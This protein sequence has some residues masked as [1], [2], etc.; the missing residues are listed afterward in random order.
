VRSG[1]FGGVGI[2]SVCEGGDG[3]SH[4]VG[5]EGGS[6]REGGREGAEGGWE[7]FVR[8]RT[9][10]LSARFIRACLLRWLKSTVP[11]LYHTQSGNGWEGVAGSMA[12]PFS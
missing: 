5:R 8:A 2:F 12:R 10:D 11:S 9:R 1:L 7:G 4:G 3:F 6:W